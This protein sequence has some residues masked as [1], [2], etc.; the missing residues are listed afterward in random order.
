MTFSSPQDPNIVLS[1]SRNLKNSK[2][3]I[4][5]HVPKI[6]QAEYKKFKS[7]AAKLRLLPEMN[8]Q[9]QITFDSHLM[10]L[11]YKSRDTHNQKYQYITYS[12]YYPPMNQAS[13]GLKSSLHIPPGTVP[14]PVISPAAASKAKSSFFMTGMTTERTEETFVRQ[15]TE[16]MK[17]EDKT[18]ITE[19]KLVK[20]NTAVIYCKSWED[21]KR[22]VEKMRDSKFE[23][24]KVIFQ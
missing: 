15:F 13:S 22:I 12:E 21:C 4:E 17:E 18:S 8:Y 14:T 9:T 19:I 1:F 11:R 10:L 16:Y 24:E 3:S 2:I 20:K 6:Y 7:M 5:K 23:N